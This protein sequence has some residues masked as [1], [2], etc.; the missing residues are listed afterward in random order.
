M[1][2]VGGMPISDD[3]LVDRLLGG[4]SM[5]GNN[6]WV[7]LGIMIPVTGFLFDNNKKYI[8]GFYHSAYAVKHYHIKARRRR[9]K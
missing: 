4:C 8:I 7:V 5:D 6:G 2:N 3:R 9:A 1:S